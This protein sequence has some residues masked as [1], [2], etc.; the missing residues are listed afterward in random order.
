MATVGL[1]GIWGLEQLDK[2]G[3]ATWKLGLILMGGAGVVGYVLMKLLI[4][5]EP[6]GPMTPQTI[7]AITYGT[8]IIC[9][10]GV[11]I[12]LALSRA[13][14]MDLKALSLVDNVINASIERLKAT[15][16]LRFTCIALGLLYG[17]LTVPIFVSME[18]ELTINEVFAES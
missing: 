11:V 3:I 1:K 8:V 16:A 5:M 14:E 17:Y 13:V 15:R 12:L 9:A 7:T 4:G 2:T 10:G 6:N 18:T